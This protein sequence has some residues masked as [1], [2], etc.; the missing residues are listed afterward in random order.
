MCVYMYISLLIS[1]CFY[2]RNRESFLITYYWPARPS[3]NQ[4]VVVE[5]E[6]QENV[7]DDGYCWRKY[8]QKK[9]KGNSNPRYSDR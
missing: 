5:I 3:R 1:Y 8:G 6:S 2:C 9:V 7:P 4:K